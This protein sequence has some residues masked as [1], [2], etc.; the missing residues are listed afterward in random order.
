M[1]DKETLMHS[2]Y[3][4]KYLD[5]DFKTISKLPVIFPF[6]KNRLFFNEKTY[7]FYSICTSYYL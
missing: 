1:D 7:V 2:C 3:V 4:L 5:Y 6:Q